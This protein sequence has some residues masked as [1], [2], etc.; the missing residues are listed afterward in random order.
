MSDY[1]EFLRG[2]GDAGIEDTSEDPRGDPSPKVEPEPTRDYF[3]EAVSIAAG[4][5]YLLPQKEHIAAVIE[6]LDD[7]ESELRHLKRVLNSGIVRNARAQAA[8]VANPV[9]AADLREC[10]R[11][12]EGSRMGRPLL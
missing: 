10:L 6:R 2:R 3:A 4:P 1:W 12:A 8:A 11:E 9:T 5:F 7:A